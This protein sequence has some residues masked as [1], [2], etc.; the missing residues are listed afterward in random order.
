VA[1]GLT[2]LGLVVA[3]ASRGANVARVANPAG[4]GVHSPV[5][6]LFDWT[7]WLGMQQVGTLISMILLVV[8]VALYWRRHPDSPV[9]LMVIAA[10]GIVWQD[11]L[12]NWSPYAVYN[13]QLWH[14][15]INWPLASVAPTVE[16]FVVIGYA[17]FYV[18]PGLVGLAVL[19][20]LQARRPVD[21]FVWRHPLITLAILIYPIGFIF[22][23]GLE[24]MCIRCGLYIYSQVIPFGSVFTG[25]TF[26]F[27]LLWESSLVTLVMIPAGILLYRDDTG[28]SVAEKL[29]QRVRGLRRHPRLGTFVVMFLVLNVAYFGYLAAFGVIRDTRVSTSVACPW[30]YP[31]AKVYDPQGMYEKAGQTGPYA[32]GVWAG[33]ESAQSG[34]PAV[35]LGSS[36]GRCSS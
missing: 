22:D 28:R 21:S 34:R 14:W 26:Q 33:W 20:K 36:N 4:R 25:T 8:G 18:G 11:P 35:T 7:H 9:P 2:I 30:P 12:V 16:P 13:P 3:N 23:A 6:Y 32:V 17:F 1:V 29:A 24:I 27:P 31:E 15:P 10:T 19:K 5:R